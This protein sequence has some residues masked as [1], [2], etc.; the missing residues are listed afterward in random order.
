MVTELVTDG[1]TLIL[2]ASL[3]SR[4]SLMS[5]AVRITIGN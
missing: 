1:E 2:V 4:A 3:A 5:D